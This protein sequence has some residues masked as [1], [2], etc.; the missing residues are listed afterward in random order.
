MAAEPHRK[1]LWDRL[2][3]LATILVPAAIALAGHFIAQGLKEAELKGQERQAAQASANA[4]ANTKIAQAGL[5]NTL[6]KSLTSP[7]PQERKLA[8]QAVLI[9]LPDQGPLLARTV[10]QSDEDEAVQVAARS[11]LKQR[12]DTLIRQLFADDAGTRVEAARELVQGWR[13]EGNAVGT[14]LDAA[15]QNRDNDNGIYN[16]A[17]VLAECAPAALA[18][19][20]EGVQQFIDLAKSKGPRTAAKTAVLEKRLAQ[21]GPGDSPQA[22]PASLAP[23]GSELSPSPPG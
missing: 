6:M 4:E 22:A 14:L 8:V 12:A 16:V 23:G 20:R 7:N 10:A 11:S 13:S 9:A 18:P 19:H 5:I 2:T 21:T 15:F 3:A 1:D 17:V